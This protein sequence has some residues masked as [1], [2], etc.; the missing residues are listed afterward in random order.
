MQA[1][2]KEILLNLFHF[3]PIMELT[4][5]KKVCRLWQKIITES[6]LQEKLIIEFNRFNKSSI[7]EKFDELQDLKTFAIAKNTIL[8]ALGI[9]N[10]NN[11][12][13]IEE[14]S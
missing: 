11:F 6:P 9:R 3:S 14:C 12:I 10:L 4:E 2:P 1:I 7:I 5:Y 13:T 8:L